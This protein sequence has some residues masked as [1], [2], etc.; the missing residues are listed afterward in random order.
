LECRK[1]LLNRKVVPSDATDFSGKSY[2]SMLKEEHADDRGNSSKARTVEDDNRSLVSGLLAVI[3][4]GAVLI[5]A[6]LIVL[7]SPVPD[8]SASLPNAATHS[9]TK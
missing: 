3:A 1:N 7:D 2:P 8:R 4:I 6:T 5:F 9:Q